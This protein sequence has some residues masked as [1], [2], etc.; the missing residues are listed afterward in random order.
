M[1]VLWALVIFPIVAPLWF[2]FWNM[3]EDPNDLDA[4]RPFL[5]TLLVLCVGLPLALLVLALVLTGH[6]LL[7]I[8]VLFA[9]V[10]ALVALEQW[11]QRR[12]PTGCARRR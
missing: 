4:A 8:G 12:Q 9:P 6:D 7:V 3:V 10:L 2:T 11:R 5:L 1:S